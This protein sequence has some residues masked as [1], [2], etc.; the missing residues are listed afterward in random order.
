MNAT[1]QAILNDTTTINAII[2]CLAAALG[3]V[4]H[5]VKKWADGEVDNPLE[6]VTQSARHSVSAMI[7][8][9]GG[10]IAFVATGVLDPMTPGALVIFGLMN[11]FT[12]D[13]AL[14]KASRTAWTD[15]ERAA[16]TTE[17]G[18]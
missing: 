14:N 3:Q 4:L 11:G 6:W 10:M 17:P 16:K 2:F 12:A 7:G 5:A 13:S 15:V 8:N 9:L 18:K 1:L